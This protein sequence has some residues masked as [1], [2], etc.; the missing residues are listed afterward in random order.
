MHGGAHVQRGS[1]VWH[2]VTGSVMVPVGSKTGSVLRPSAVDLTRYSLQ[3]LRYVAYWSSVKDLMMVMFPTVHLGTA[4]T[5]HLA[6]WGSPIGRPGSAYGRFD[7]MQPTWHPV[8]RMEQFIHAAVACGFDNDDLQFARLAV[9]VAKHD[10]P[11]DSEASIALW[12]RVRAQ[13][14]VLRCP[15]HPCAT[16][17]AAMAWREGHVALLEQPV[18]KR[19]WQRGRSEDLLVINTQR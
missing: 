6:W 3:S 9:E 17:I 10:P 1:H 2:A 18:R 5:T 8:L 12:H 7:P 16:F 15:M 11:G 14:E 13:G 19:W 4:G